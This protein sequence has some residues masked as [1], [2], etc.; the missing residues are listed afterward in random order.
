MDRRTALKALATITVAPVA[1]RA[2]EPKL[3]ESVPLKDTLDLLNIE[4]TEDKAWVQERLKPTK[5][6]RVISRIHVDAAKDSDHLVM[7]PTG[8][9]HH[10]NSVD[11]LAMRYHEAGGSQDRAVP[12]RAHFYP[13]SR[14]SKG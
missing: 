5:V 11:P 2:G 14:A 7:G 4:P 9:G 12:S 13:D 1:A 3:P 10:W 8:P 6:T